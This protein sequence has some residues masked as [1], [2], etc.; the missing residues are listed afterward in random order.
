MSGKEAEN[1]K[2]YACGFIGDVQVQ[3]D[4]KFWVYH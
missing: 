3:G 4:E 2:V 1:V